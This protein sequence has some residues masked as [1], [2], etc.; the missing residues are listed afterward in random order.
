MSASRVGTPERKPQ[1]G[2]SLVEMLVAL[3]F[4]SILMAGMAVVFRTSI[5]TFSEIQSGRTSPGFS[6]SL[7]ASGNSGSG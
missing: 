2:F 5:G 1:Y 4:M 7:P 3:V 6:E